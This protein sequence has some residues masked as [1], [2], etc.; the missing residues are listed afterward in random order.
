M[1]NKRDWLFK[2]KTIQTTQMNY[3]W[4]DV[5]KDKTLVNYHSDERI[6]EWRDEW[7][8]KGMNMN[9]ITEWQ[10]RLHALIE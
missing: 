7:T 2:K 4:G 8:S 5:R 6:T 9:D 1:Q 3:S 10:N